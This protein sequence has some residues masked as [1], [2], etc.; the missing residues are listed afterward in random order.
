MNKRKGHDDDETGRSE[1]LNSDIFESSDAIGGGLPKKPR[2]QTPTPNVLSTD[3]HS[4][5]S[6]IT[7]P[8]NSSQQVNI[9][10]RVANSNSMPHI[11]LKE[12]IHSPL[13]DSILALLETSKF[14]SPQMFLNEYVSFIRNIAAANSNYTNEISNSLVMR[15]FLG[16]FFC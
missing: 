7:K 15:L 12:S 16:A 10:D 5:S 9:L 14:N 11:P 8:I 3:N 13:N 4:S 6:N 2:L 1:A